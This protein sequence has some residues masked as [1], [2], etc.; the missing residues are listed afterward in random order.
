MAVTV[1]IEA[2]IDRKRMSEN[3][4]NIIGSCGNALKGT[5]EVSGMV[6]VVLVLITRVSTLVLMATNF[7]A[8]RQQSSFSRSR[9]DSSGNSRIGGNDL[10]TAGR[11]AK[12]RVKMTAIL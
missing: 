4:I 2:V 8:F 5:I 7:G 9:D 6:V 12:V 3:R 11:A 1:M 10:Q